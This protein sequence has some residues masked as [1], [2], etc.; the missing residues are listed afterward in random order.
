MLIIEPHSGLANRMRVIAS[1]L[2]IATELQLR[3]CLVWNANK[4]L[5]AL[6]T[7]LFEPI[8]GLETMKPKKIFAF[9]RSTNSDR[10]FNSYF[11]TLINK[12]L[13]IDY[14]VKDEDFKTFIW[15][16]K[17]DINQVCAG[18]PTVY[19]KTCQE[20][21]ENLAAFQ[22]FRPVAAISRIIDRQTSNYNAHTI[23]IHIRRGDNIQS[24]QQS[25]LHLFIEKIEEEIRTDHR[26]NF[27]L[28][29]DD[30]ATEQELKALFGNRISTNPKVI[31][32][33]TKQ[34][35]I[36]AV[37]DLYCLSRTSKLYGSYWS[38]YSEIAAKIGQIP[39]FKL[40]EFF[41]TPNVQ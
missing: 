4:E 28:A 15:N 16:N 20:F 41:A 11:A 33:D 27:F 3:L 18:N 40:K 5:N 19:M 32:R 36:D 6:F 38:S 35:I 39:L 30:L 37:I 29:T 7:H 8:Q 23:G 14:C 9:V 2:T 1:G 26:A 17:I 25:P 24:I 34:G 21:G 12:L 10:V 13:G 31:N 22:H